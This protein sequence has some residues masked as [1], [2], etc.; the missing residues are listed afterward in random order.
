MNSLNQTIVKNL[1]FMGTQSIADLSN[2]IGRSIPRITIG[3]HQLLENGIISSEGFAPSTGGR[4]ATNY[5]LN[6]D[7]LPHILAIT[8]DQYSVTITLLDLSNVA[9]KASH[10]ESINLHG[11]SD[12]DKKI[13]KH[14]DQYLMDQMMD[15]ILAIGITMPG[16]VNSVKGVNTSYSEGHPLFNIKSIVQQHLHCPTYIENDSTAI[17]IAE[18][19]FGKARGVPD[20]LIINLNWGVGLGMILGNELFK[21]STGFAG[22]FSHI[23]L[24]NLNKLCSCG[25]RGCLEVE[26]SLAAALESASSKLETGEISQL[27]EI[28]TSEG[29]ISIDQLMDAAVAGDQVAIAAFARTGYMLGKGIATLIHL[30]NPEKV[31]ISGQGAKVGDILLPQIQTSILEFS[32]NRLSKYTRIEISSLQDAQLIGSACIAVL[33]LSGVIAIKN[34]K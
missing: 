12:L 13:L 21:G 20:A 32:I 31:I 16:F 8:I 11:D 22:E 9:I 23:P 33:A 14:I 15:K 26:A 29:K 2:N 17:A 5:S 10:S 18:H 28:Y 25:K 1:Y 19:R 30:I 27:S 4:R 3:I 34:N 7:D 6:T 24:S